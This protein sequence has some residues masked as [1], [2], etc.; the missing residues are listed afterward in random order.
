MRKALLPLLFA[1]L[2]ILPQAAQ[3]CLYTQA[4]EPVGS[5]SQSFFTR[6]MAEAATTV[7]IAVAGETRAAFGSDPRWR[8]PATTFYVVDRI[9][10]NSPDRFA[11]FVGTSGP[12]H[13]DVE[14]QHWVDENGRVTPYPYPVEQEPVVGGI[15]SMTSC[16]PGFLSVREGEAY[17]VFRDGQGRLLGQFALYG[18]LTTAAFPLVPARLGTREG[19]LAWLGPLRSGAPAPQQTLSPDRMAVRFPRPITAQQA[20]RWLRATGLAPFVIRVSDE[21]VTD[22]T[23]VP[24]GFADTALVERAVADARANDGSKALAILAARMQAGITA[25]LLENDSLIRRHVW[26]LAEA[27]ARYR[28]AG[29]EPLIAAMEVTG[30]AA[31]LSRLR[32]N[33]HGA[34]VI[35]GTLANGVLGIGLPLADD[36]QAQADASW[37]EATA[38][39]L[40]RLAAVAGTRPLPAAVMKPPQPEPDP[41]A[42]SDCIRFGREEAAA[43]AD[44]PER[45]RLGELRVFGFEDAAVCSADSGVL[46]CDLA[47]NTSVRVSWAG[48]EGGFRIS[49]NGARLTFDAD[50]L[51]CTGD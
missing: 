23:R 11:L 29:A 7:D 16:H 24:V 13:R 15:R 43:L 10:G 38:S 34:E 9:K 14:A 22:E 36:E 42:W 3:A 6:K 33:P 50:V 25:E 48:W 47:P 41:F 51:Q 19:W 18:D 31:A 20:E 5:A 44:L 12:D 27:A 1:G 37:N 49:P 46:S 21:S 30:P 32:N 39:L 4:P 17:L 28:D 8:T 26:L 35:D 2:A 40:A 45:G